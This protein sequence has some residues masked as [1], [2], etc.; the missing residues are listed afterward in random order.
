[1][2]RSLLPPLLL[3]GPLKKYFSLFAA[4]LFLCEQYK[5]ALSR[6][7]ADP[8]PTLKAGSGSKHFQ[9]PDPDIIPRSSNLL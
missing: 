6:K 7:V 2:A 4:F 8:G 9:T 5:L 1:M 3:A